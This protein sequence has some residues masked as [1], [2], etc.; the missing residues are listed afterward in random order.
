MTQLL[1]TVLFSHCWEK[2]CSI[3]VEKKIRFFFFGSFGVDVC[4]PTATGSLNQRQQHF[5]F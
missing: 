4:L 3:H 5:S 1:K 2:K